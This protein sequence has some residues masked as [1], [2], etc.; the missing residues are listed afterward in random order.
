MDMAMKER[1][2]RDR[3]SS[4]E[5]GV[6]GARAHARSVCASFVRRQCIAQEVSRPRRR[7]EGEK[8][9][10]AARMSPDH[11]PIRT[12]CLRLQVVSGHTGEVA[13]GRELSLFRKTKNGWC[14]T[15][16]EKKTN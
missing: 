12:H 13:L 1:I 3:A 4:T 10:F 11:G 7:K 5:H 15:P 2:K 16:K 6:A 8:K 9:T 14:E